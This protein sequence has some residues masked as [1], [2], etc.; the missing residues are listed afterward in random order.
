MLDRVNGVIGAFLLGALAS[1]YG[2]QIWSSSERSYHPTYYGCYKHIEQKQ[3]QIGRLEDAN[4]R[5][6]DYTGWLALLTG[7]LVVVSFIQIRYLIRADRNAVRS[8]DAAMLAIGSDR[9]W[10][11]FDEIAINRAGDSTLDGAP[12]KNAV[13][14]EIKWRNRGRSPAL[15][16]ECF[17][18]MRIIPSTDNIPPVFVPHW[19]TDRNASPIG[20]GA[21]ATSPPRFVLDAQIDEFHK[22]NT[23][24]IIY[25]AIRYRDVFNTTIERFSEACVKVRY[26][27]LQKINDG[28]LVPRYEPTAFGPQ[29]TAV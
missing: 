8:A 21:I 16:C 1:F 6:A 12:F 26:G 3:V 9:A 4:D 18:D 7:G 28:P 14:F 27:G 23:V 10:M 22:W 19:G 15:R 24:V 13:L 2:W 25:S 20:P 17:I 29:N 5:I 11:T